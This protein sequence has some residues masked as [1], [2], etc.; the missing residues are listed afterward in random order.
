MCVFIC[1]M[2]DI[3]LRGIV[4]LIR[5]SFYGIALKNNNC[6]KKKK[7]AVNSLDVFQVSSGRRLGGRS[8]H[9]FRPLGMPRL[10]KK[11]KKFTLLSSYSDHLLLIHGKHGSNYVSTSLP[12]SPVFNSRWFIYN[13]IIIIIMIIYNITEN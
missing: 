1:Q 4:H 3:F 11:N 8:P 9:R 5:S 7:N 6:S 2:L 12:H 13:R 10:L